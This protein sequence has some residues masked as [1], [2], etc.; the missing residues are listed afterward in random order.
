MSPVAKRTVT[1][2]LA[3]ANAPLRPARRAGRGGRPSGER[4]RYLYLAPLVV[5]L[6]LSSLVPAGYA[7]F[8]SFYNW[9]W[10]STFSFVGLQNYVHLLG[11]EEY[12]LSFVRTGLFTVMAVAA[13][14]VIGLALA[15]AVQRVSRGIAWL[16]T[17]FI[18]PLMVSGMVVSLIWKVMLDPTLGVIP[19]LLS[20]LG[21]Q[22]LDLLGDANLALPAL[23]GLD[24]WWQTG[25]VFIILSAGLA[26]LPHEPLEA[27]S[28]D[29]ASGWQRFRYITLPMLTP[30]ILTVA[31]IRAVDC[32]KVFA[33]P[34]GATN[35]GPGQSTF[36]TQ[37]LAYRTAFRD[38]HMSQSMAMMVTYSLIIVLAVVVVLLV[39]KAV[40]RAR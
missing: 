12:W 14:I 29:G 6:G 1:E 25:F 8:L 39:R 37:L 23:A 32:L 27:A 26:A 38:F 2:A 36:T 3:V 10:G 7:L 30:L 9:D 31:A 16:R 24:T 28:V 40:N 33:L 35:G 11:D 5:L 22:H 15:V 18:L 4:G 19:H 34:Y 13:E 17:V 21:I 20:F